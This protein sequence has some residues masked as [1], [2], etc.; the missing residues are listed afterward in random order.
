MTS[1][2]T[3]RPAAA[4]RR[5]DDRAAGM[6]TVTA[7]ITA[8]TTKATTYPRLLLRMDRLCRALPPGVPIARLGAGL[9]LSL[10]GADGL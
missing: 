5:R 1:A 8:P 6:P 3:R 10:D 7:S 2:V 4:D 9:R